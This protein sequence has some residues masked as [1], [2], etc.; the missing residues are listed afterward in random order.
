MIKKER[1]D[2]ADVLRGLAVLGIVLLHS[3]EHFNFY[4]YPGTESTLL[5]FSNKAI[6]DSTS[7][8]LAGKAYG[9]FALLFGFS[10]YIQDSRQLEKGNDF[11]L[12]FMWRLL[13]LFLWGQINAMF[14]TA[15][16]LVL[17]AVTGFVLPLFARCSNR[18][19]LIAAAIMICCT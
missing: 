2:V 8:L 10:F 12:R 5:Q 14:F 17:Y 16:V 11:R 19:L 13:L 4:S 1:I 18:T 3:L 9:I 6:W 15:E 7:F